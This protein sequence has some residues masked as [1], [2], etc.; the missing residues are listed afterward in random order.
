MEARQIIPIET[1]SEPDAEHAERL[2]TFQEATRNFQR[3]LLEE[4]LL[5]T[6]WNVSEAARR[7]DLARSHVY[8]LIH[9]FGLSRRRAIASVE[10]VPEAHAAP[11]TP[12]LVETTA[13]QGF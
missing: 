3:K 1:L 4:T 9:S 8:N 7:L 11:D 13:I 12:S 2:P 6:E 5:A 10:E